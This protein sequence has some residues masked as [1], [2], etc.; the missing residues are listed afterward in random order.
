MLSCLSTLTP[1][2]LAVYIGLVVVAILVYLLPVYLAYIH[3]MTPWK[4]FLR[5]LLLTPFVT[6]LII[7]YRVNNTEERMWRRLFGK[8]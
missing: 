4:W 6:L 7:I 2:E 5:S 3:G 1:L 8:E